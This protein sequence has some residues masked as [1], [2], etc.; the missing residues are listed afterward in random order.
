MSSF[1]QSLLQNDPVEAALIGVALFCL[2]T[3]LLITLACGVSPILFFK[4]RQA[5]IDFSA[6]D[7]IK[8][9]MNGVNPSILFQAAMKARNAGLM[10]DMKKL[11]EHSLNGGSPE[12]I[13]KVLERARASGQK[14]SLEDLC[15]SDLKGENLESL[16][17]K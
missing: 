9:R 3:A 15:K 13:V 8:L 1:L 2:L 16:L 6:V 17:K 10:I 7:I 5:G 12:K 11:L 4:V 14:I